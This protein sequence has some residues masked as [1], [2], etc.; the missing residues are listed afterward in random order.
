MARPKAEAARDTR[1]EIL[2]A[3]LD[4]F[5]EHGFAGASVRDLARAAGVRESA[6]YHYFPSKDAL[7][8]AVIQSVVEFRAGAAV[9]QMRDLQDRTLEEILTSLTEFVIAR[10]RTP[11]ERK[12]WRILMTEGPRLTTDGRVSWHNLVQ[13]TRKPMMAMLHDM[14]R[15]GGL[16]RDLDVD[17]FVLHFIG[18]II[19][20]TNAPMG[21]GKG[22]VDMTHARFVREHVAFLMRA[23]APEEKR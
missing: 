23:V 6:L 7:F 4:L 2:E 3:A 21:G 8:E 12:F 20:Y 19:L 5:A 11:I 13:R 1:S 15:R 14:V 18:P 22:P 16:R 9:A 10:L 17:T